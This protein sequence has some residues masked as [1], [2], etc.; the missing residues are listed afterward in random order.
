MTRSELP[1]TRTAPV[2]TSGLTRSDD[3]LALLENLDANHR[4]L[5]AAL[6]RQV[7]RINAIESGL[8]RVDERTRK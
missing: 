8:A 1:T 6:D 5:L 3:H 2:P 4:E 7:T